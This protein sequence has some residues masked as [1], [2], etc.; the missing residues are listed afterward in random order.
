MYVTDSPED[1]VQHILRF[2]ERA[3]AA[4]ELAVAVA[5]ADSGLTAEGQTNGRPTAATDERGK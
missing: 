2:P 5:D 3:R 4:D 1:V